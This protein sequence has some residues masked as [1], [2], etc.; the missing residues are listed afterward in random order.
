MLPMMSSRAVQAG[1]ISSIKGET[2]SERA[3]RKSGHI[4]ECTRIQ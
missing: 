1:G 3:Y 4:G 2:D